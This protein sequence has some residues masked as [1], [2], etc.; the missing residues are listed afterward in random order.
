MV[1]F[2]AA[3]N[4]AKMALF[5]AASRSVVN[6]RNFLEVKGMKLKRIFNK[7]AGRKKT[8]E[9]RGGAPPS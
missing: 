9:S 6:P 8:Y 7:K 3:R 4:A 5:K 1:L 2:S